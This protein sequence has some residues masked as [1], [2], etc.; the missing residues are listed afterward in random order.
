LD[1]TMRIT[2]QKIIETMNSNSKIPDLRTAAF[3]VALRKIARA[4][5]EMGL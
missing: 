1:D 5:Q 3:I 2:L 4:Y